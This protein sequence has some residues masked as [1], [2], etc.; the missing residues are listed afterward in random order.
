MPGKLP[1]ELKA[2]ELLRV[3]EGAGGVRRPT[4]GS[5]VTLKMP[6]G[7]LV[8][9]PATGVVKIGVIS[10]SLRKTGIALDEFLR[11]LGR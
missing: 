7:Q 11:M 1:R 6:N 4:R 8:T 9:I 10:A 3:L 5:H 2:E